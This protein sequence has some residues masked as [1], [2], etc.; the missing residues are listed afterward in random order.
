MPLKC[1]KWLQVQVEVQ[2]YLVNQYHEVSSFG[3][4]CLRNYL[5]VQNLQVVPQ[6]LKPETR[7]HP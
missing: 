7:K 4:K 5:E 3:F 2:L 1:P 6:A